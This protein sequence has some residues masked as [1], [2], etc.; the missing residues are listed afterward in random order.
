MLRGCYAALHS[1]L[2]WLHYSI[3]TIRDCIDDA[4]GL[5]Y[6]RA[7][8]PHPGNRRSLGSGSDPAPCGA[9]SAPPIGTFRRR[10]S[11]NPPPRVPWLHQDIVRRQVAPRRR[12]CCRFGSLPAPFSWPW[13]R[14]REWPKDRPAA[15]PRP[16]RWRDRNA[17]PGPDRSRSH[18]PAPV[19]PSHAIGRC[20]SELIRARCTSHP[21]L[22]NDV[23]FHLIRFPDYFA[24][25]ELNQTLQWMRISCKIHELSYLYFPLSFK[26]ASSS[27]GYLL[28]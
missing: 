3:C 12:R 17:S 28:V 9:R 26:N 13:D 8:E 16:P 15:R 14:Q 2:D 25:A 21:R 19:T 5:H 1:V 23:P 22:D 6:P 7:P 27:N 10:R 24:L 20:F 4:R 18:E 11:A